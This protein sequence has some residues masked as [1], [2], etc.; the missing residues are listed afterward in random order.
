MPVLDPSEY[1]ASYFDGA[2]QTL[3]HNA[4][5]SS[6]ERW[7]RGDGNNPDDAGE[8]WAEIARR[9]SANNRFQNQTVLEVGCAKGFVVEDLRA[10]GIQAFGLDVSAYA[11]GE[12]DPSVQ[13]YLTVGD[14]LTV[15]SSYSR[16][17]F[18]WLF[19]MRF[20]ECI[21]DSDIQPIIDEMKRVSR[22]QFHQIGTSENPLYYQQK[23][24]AQWRA[25]NWGT[26]CTLFFNERPNLP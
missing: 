6:Y 2:S 22:N 26:K 20:F 10:L 12:A 16:N 11:I 3:R 9:L 7:V 21:P 1:D 13:P 24:E 19:S 18:D 15:L 25:Y 8:Q 14:A 4:G 23:T 17:Q 5:Y